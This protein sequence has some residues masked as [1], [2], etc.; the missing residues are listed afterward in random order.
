MTIFAK[1]GEVTHLVMQELS[2]PLRRGGSIEDRTHEISGIWD[3]RSMKLTS[4]FSC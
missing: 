1:A 4:A 2:P 3:L